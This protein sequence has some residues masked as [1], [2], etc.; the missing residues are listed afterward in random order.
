MTLIQDTLIWDAHSCLPLEPGWDLSPIKRQLDADYNFVSINIGMDFNGMVDT[1]KTLAYM[2]RWILTQDHLILASTVQDIFKAKEQNKLALAFDLEG[3]VPLGDSLDMIDLYYD[4]G[5][6]QM[7]LAYNTQNSVCSGCQVKDKGLT[8]LGHQVVQRMN[9]VGM[10]LDLS[11]MGEK[12]TLDCMA[13]TAK[14]PIF[15]HSNPKGLVDHPRNITDKQMKRCAD[16]NGVVCI[17]G[18]GPFLG[19]NNTSSE[20]FFEHIDYAVQLL[21][22]DHVGIGLDY[23]YNQDEVEIFHKKYPDSFPLTKNQNHYEL[24]E[25]EQ[26]KDLPELMEKAGYTTQNIQNIFGLNMLRIAQN[27]WKS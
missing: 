11:H 13:I 4:M 16:L 20:R 9:E 23:V 1:L 3:S 17:N 8:K 27:N 6:R 14:P 24:V 7:H 12:S 26:I 10:I 22:D 21:G 19:D 5:V 25:P 2:R 18:I 15:S